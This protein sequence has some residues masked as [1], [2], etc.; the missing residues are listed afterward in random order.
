MLKRAMLESLS[1]MGIGVVF[2]LLA[3]PFE[4]FR[5]QPILNGWITTIREAPNLVLLSLVVLGILGVLWG[6]LTLIIWG[7]LTLNQSLAKHDF[8]K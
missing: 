2:D 5:H 7:F 3:I 1:F 8:T 4:L 6:I